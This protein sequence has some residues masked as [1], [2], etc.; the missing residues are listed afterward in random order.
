M[1][2]VVVYV[3]GSAISRLNFTSPAEGLHA[4]SRLLLILFQIDSSSI[5]KYFLIVNEAPKPW[6]LGYIPTSSTYYFFL[7]IVRVRVR[8]DT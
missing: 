2:I 3:P 8:K 5:T 1:A 4:A 7:V 6:I